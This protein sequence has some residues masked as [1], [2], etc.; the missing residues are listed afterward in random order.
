MTPST[1]VVGGSSGIGAATQAALTAAGHDVHVIDRT[2]GVDITDHTTVHAALTR[3]GPV[4]HLV[5]S[6]GHVTPGQFADLTAADWHQHLAVN[7]TGAALTATWRAEQPQPGAIVLVSSTS[8]LRPSPGW[9]AYGATKAALASLGQSLAVEWAPRL[10]VYTIAPGRCATAL[11][12]RLAPN[13]DP[14]TIM[15]PAEVAAVIA[16]LIDRDPA[17]VLTGQP[18]EVKRR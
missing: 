3:I 6:A 17:G 11:R 13:E 1:L 10:R 12:A 2:H 4:D 16:D 5:Y 9:A 8:G 15:Q 7:V 14:E 18:I